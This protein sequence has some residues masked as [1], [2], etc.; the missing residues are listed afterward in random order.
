MRYLKCKGNVI[1]FLILA[2]IGSSCVNTKKFI[3]FNDL[4]NASGEQS[5]INRPA[6]KIEPGDILQITVSTIDR[7]ISQLLNPTTNGITGVNTPVAP[8]YLVDSTGAIEMPLVGKIFVGGKTT[9]EINEIVKEALS[10]S[11]K[12]L[13]VSTRLLNFRISIL[14][15]VARP[16][17]Y[18]I[19]NERVSLLEALSMAG[20]VNLGAKRNDLM[21]IRETE[22]KRQYVTIDLN[23]SKTLSSPYFYLSNK[24][25]IYVK[26]S[27]NRLFQSSTGFQI[28]PTLFGALSLALVIYSTFNN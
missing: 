8:G 16:G 15:D 20:D 4:E 10:K 19:A 1:A 27:S 25:V 23:D 13:F 17:S 3:Y 6:I 18:N 21:L 12:N 2:F 9:T 26:P 7:D 28:L 24:D 5:I 22:G 14:G 11:V